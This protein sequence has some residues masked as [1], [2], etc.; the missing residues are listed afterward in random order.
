[1][2]KSICVCF[3]LLTLRCFTHS[4]LV[5]LMSQGMLQMVLLNLLYPI[6]ATKLFWF[7]CV[8]FA[9]SWNPFPIWWL[10]F[11][12]LSWIV[13]T[14]S[15]LYNAAWNPSYIFC[16]FD[17]EFITG[18]CFRYH[19]KNAWKNGLL[20]LDWGTPVLMND[21]IYWVVN[22]VNIWI[23]FLLP[24]YIYLFKIGFRSKS[25]WCSEASSSNLFR[26]RNLESAS[27]ICLFGA[28]FMGLQKFFVVWWWI[29]F[30]K[31]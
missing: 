14:V 24:F 21:R 27:R 12:R 2:L 20:R 11:L 25:I 9:F 30:Y 17:L 13:V 5:V 15:G 26:G 1:M 19:W 10:P 18:R 8:Y 23:C 29:C 3:Y 16:H 4:E 6:F 31:R 22:L 28:W 7:K